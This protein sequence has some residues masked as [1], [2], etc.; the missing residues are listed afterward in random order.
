MGQRLSKLARGWSP[1]LCLFYIKQT[2][3]L[4]GSAVI[5]DCGGSVVSAGVPLLTPPPPHLLKER[6]VECCNNLLSYLGKIAKNAS[7]FVRVVGLCCCRFGAEGRSKGASEALPDEG[8]QKNDGGNFRDSSSSF[9]DSH[10]GYGGDEWR[11]E[12]DYGNGGE[13][14]DGFENQ[15]GWSGF[16]SK[17]QENNDLYSGKMD[18]QQNKQRRAD[19]AGSAAGSGG[20]RNKKG[21]SSQSPNDLPRFNGGGPQKNARVGGGMSGNGDSREASASVAALENRRSGKRTGDSSTSSSSRPQP[22]SEPKIAD[23][24]KVRASSRGDEE[25]VCPGEFHFCV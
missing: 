14:D 22:S 10:R 2:K 19:G 3:L 23:R 25:E 16:G 9:A 18:Q 24:H 11:D 12:G 13:R 20:R 1:V 7:V 17:K 6:V 21:A 8:G 4:P 15:G 5:V